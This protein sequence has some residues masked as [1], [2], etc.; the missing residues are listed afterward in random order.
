[1]PRRPTTGLA[2]LLE[3]PDPVSLDDGLSELWERDHVRHAP[4]S[5]EP[6]EFSTMAQAA[7]MEWAL[8]V[9]TPKR[10]LDLDRFAFQREL[11]GPAWEYDQDGAIKK[12][13][14]LGV[15]ENILRWALRWADRGRT[16]LYVLPIGKLAVEFSTMRL[17][18]VI[19]ASD[20]L[21]ARSRTR[22]KASDTKR[23][24]AIGHGF[25]AIR[26]SQSKDELDSVDADV[27]VL[28]EYDRQVQAHLA[29]AEQRVTGPLSDGLIRR[30]STP[31]IPNFGIDPVY[32]GGTKK[33]WFVRC[34]GLSKRGKRGDGC[35][36]WIPMAGTET[37]DRNVRH[38]EERDRYYLACH[39]C[40]AELDVIQGHYV[41]E[42]PDARYQSYHLP[43][44]V[45]PGIDLRL[46]VRN[47]EKTKPLD[48]KTHKNKDLGEAWVSEE[49]G[50]SQKA[51]DAATRDFFME[52]EGYSGNSL[53]TMGIDVANS[54]ALN[55]RISKHLDE[56]TKVMLW[57][58]LV[59][60]YKAPWGTTHLTAYEILSELMK[61]F[62][63][64]TAV[65]DNEPGGRLTNA[66]AQRHRGRVWRCVYVGERSKLIVADEEAMQVKVRRL[67][68]VDSTLD[69]IRKQKNLLAIDRPPA[70]SP[71]DKKTGW[72]NNLKALVLN[73]EEDEETGDLTQ[74]WIKTGPDDY[75]H[76]EV[77]DVIATHMAYTMIY[78]GQARAADNTIAPTRDTVEQVGDWQR[79]GGDYVDD[80]EEQWNDEDQDHPLQGW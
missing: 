20:Y 1:M 12:A 49:A 8:K 10:P 2:G 40:G 35:G 69:L 25:F 11:Y 28:D 43:K 21:R 38:D 5:E 15:S 19:A 46:I 37:L 61:R 6:D 26:G 13:A 51:I 4:A 47:S 53:V 72:D 71:D 36:E 22:E 66:W 50:L 74:E 48:I 80:V 29:D 64:H 67:E 9:P 68:A 32:E 58:G 73:I 33:R 59:D 23:L 56:D 55:V 60:D 34:G 54:R 18:P 75:A 45:V 70:K 41:A 31:T 30:A 65:I 44:F 63:V 39:H 14:Q 27:L 57:A 42:N 3:E 24:K 7:F 62:R 16:A 52:R 79:A 78:E 77:Y 76:A 17:A